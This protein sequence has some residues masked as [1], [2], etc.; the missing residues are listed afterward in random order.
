MMPRSRSVRGHHDLAPLLQYG[1]GLWIPDL[2]R[3]THNHRDSAANLPD[4][5][6]D[7][8]GAAVARAGP[9]WTWSRRYDDDGRGNRVFGSVR[10]GNGG[11]GG[12]RRS[13]GNASP[14]NA[15]LGCGRADVRHHDDCG[16]H[17]RAA[18]GV[19]RSVGDGVAVH[20]LCRVCLDARR[21]VGDHF[22]YRFRFERSCSADNLLD[23][24]AV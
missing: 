5:R 10:D 8:S 15:V 19:A 16:L 9:T 17:D 3:S 20:R 4:A 2:T 7:L 1:A 22:L 13:C 18:R 12:L 6:G 21:A 11:R 23:R 24:S 14:G